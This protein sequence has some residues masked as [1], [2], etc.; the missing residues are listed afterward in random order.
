[1]KQKFI[2]FLIFAVLLPQVVNAQWFWESAESLYEQGL[3]YYKSKDYQ[4]AITYLSNAG[5]KGS[6]QG[7]N[8][9]G[10]MYLKGIGV[11]QNFAQA[12]QFFLAGYNNDQSRANSQYWMGYCYYAGCGVQTNYNTAYKFFKSAADQGQTKANRYL[13]LMYYYGEGLPKNYRNAVQYFN[14]A[15]NEND[16]ISQIFMGICYY[17]GTGVPQDTN[18]GNSYLS[19]AAKRSKLAQK[20]FDKYNSWW[21]KAGRFIDKIADDIPYF[22]TGYR[23]GQALLGE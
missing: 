16:L 12:Y 8:R 9:L 3:N 21:S 13:G 11:N 4:N 20:I 18:L 14:Y 17:D 2:I 1:M 6:A 23:L 22:G 19:Q 10:I 15:A 5:E 7:Y